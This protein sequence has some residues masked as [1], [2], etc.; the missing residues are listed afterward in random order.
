MIFLARPFKERPQKGN[1][2]HEK[3]GWLMNRIKQLAY[4][5]LA[6]LPNPAPQVQGA[7]VTLGETQG[8]IQTIAQFLIVISMVI[9][10][11]MIV[12]G[13]IRWMT[14]GSEK[15]KKIVMNGIIGAAIVL[16]VGVIL[17]TLAGV[18]TRSFFG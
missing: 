14:Q 11:I 6:L 16:A 2:S 5:G 7:P 10:V 13:G 8:L 15:G 4:S 9:A 17:Q 18:I 12:W 3:R 1:N